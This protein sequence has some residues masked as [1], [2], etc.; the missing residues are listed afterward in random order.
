MRDGLNTCDPS[1][2][3]SHEFMAAKIPR[4][5]KKK[6]EREEGYKIRGIHLERGL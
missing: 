2:R 6:R 4:S 1:G 5:K 3:L